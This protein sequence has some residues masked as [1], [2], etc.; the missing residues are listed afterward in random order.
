MTDQ[1]NRFYLDPDTPSPVPADQQEQFV[2]DG[3]PVVRNVHFPSA[4]LFRADPAMATGLGVVVMPGGGYVQLSE[5]FEGRRVAQWF[6]S[7]GVTALVL[8]YRLPP[9]HRYPAP[10][11]DGQA[12]IR[13]MRANAHD[14]GVCRDRIGAA[15]F[16][17]GGHLAACVARA[18]LSDVEAKVDF[19]VLGYAG[20]SLVKPYPGAGLWKNLIGHD[21]TD[22]MRSRLS[23]DQHVTAAS[24]PAFLFHTSD[25]GTVDARHSVDY[26]L[27]CRDHKVPA[28]LH[29]FTAGGHGYAGGV[30]GPGWREP[31]ARWLSQLD[32]WT[33]AR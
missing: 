31:C 10:M 19:L 14:W 24:P 15:G 30:N 27:A 32:R 2:V 3:W 28:E 5:E 13:L 6:N 21:T 18:G 23:A 25:D 12:A 4:E 16:S 17:A 22:E 29:I 33:T 8:R 20:I 11:I 9:A 1:P 26:H 7:I